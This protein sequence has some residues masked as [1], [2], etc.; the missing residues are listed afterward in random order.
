[1][2]GARA[3]RACVVL[4]GVKSQDQRGKNRFRK[5]GIVVATDVAGRGLDKL[6]LDTLCDLPSLSPDSHFVSLFCSL[7]V[8]YYQFLTCP[9]HRHL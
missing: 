3:G 1:M 2:S 6:S 9:Q 5:G 8:A 7:N 4:H